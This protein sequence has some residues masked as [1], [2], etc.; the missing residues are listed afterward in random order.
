[1][2]DWQ[3]DMFAFEEATHLY[4]LS[5]LGFALIKR[6]DAFTKYRMDEGKLARY[7]TYDIVFCFLLSV[8]SL[9]F[10]LWH[11]FLIEVEDGYNIYKG[12]HYHCSTHAADVL[13]TLHVLCTRGGI[14]K[15]TN[16]SDLSKFPC[17]CVRAAW[18]C[19]Y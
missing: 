2:D 18:L 11:S 7:I 10:F 13:R 14:W 16:A 4:P 5:V 3:F 1:M 12:Q 17:V 9:S 15:G 6:T 19:L 8:S